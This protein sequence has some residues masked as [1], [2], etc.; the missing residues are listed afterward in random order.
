MGTWN[1]KVL[2]TVMVLTLLPLGA[3]AQGQGSADID[4]LATVLETL[5]VTAVNDLEFGDVVQ[6][7]SSTVSPEDAEAGSF[8]VNGEAGSEVDVTFSLPSVLEQTFDP[9]LT[10]D[11]D[12]SPTSARH[13]TSDDASA[14]TSFDPDTGATTSLDFANGELF[15]YIGGTIDPTPTQ[16][17]GNYEGTITLTIEYTGN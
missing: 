8:F 14:G 4:V 10:M 3:Q 13:N 2:F 11:I 6:G 1:V 16:E 7:Q 12:F 9:S 15:V 17:P 5:T